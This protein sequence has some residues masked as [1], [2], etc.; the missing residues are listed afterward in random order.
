MDT[1]VTPAAT[2]GIITTPS[3]AK[4]FTI[5][6]SNLNE[7][8]PRGECSFLLRAPEPPP[9]MVRELRPVTV[10]RRGEY[11][12]CAQSPET[13]LICPGPRAD[14]FKILG[15]YFFCCGRGSDAGGTMFFI[16]R[17]TTMLP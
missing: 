4:S 13:Q 6:P 1:G 16:R 5:S 14:R 3:D 7:R 17:Y 10:M 8:L 12:E 15:S 9:I 2:F 11:R